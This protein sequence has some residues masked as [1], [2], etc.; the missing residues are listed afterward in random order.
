MLGE[1]T[2]LAIVKAMTVDSFL[3]DMTNLTGL[4]H[5]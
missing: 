3:Q 5:M 1:E 2:T 4:E